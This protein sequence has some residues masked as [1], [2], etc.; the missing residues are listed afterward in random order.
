M[1]NL[2]IA[3]EQFLRADCF[4]ELHDEVHII[5]IVKNSYDYQTYFRVIIKVPR[6]KRA[7]DIVV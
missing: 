5:S 4:D 1:L 3:A 7:F 6:I 2:S